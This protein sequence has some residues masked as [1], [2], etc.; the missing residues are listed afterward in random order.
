MK[1]V[2]VVTPGGLDALRYEDVPDPVPPPGWLTLEVKAAGVNHLDVWVRKG[3]PIAR[4]PIILGSDAAGVVRET[5]ERALLNPALSCGACELC[6][7]GDKPMCRDYEIFGEHRDGAQAGLIVAPPASLIP[8][9]DDLSFEEAAA[10]PLVFLTAWRM[11]LTRGRLRAGED[12]LI[13]GAG[14]GVGVACVQLAKLAGARVIAT[15]SSDA[16]AEKVAA[17]GADL[18][19]NPSKEDVVA[20]IKALTGKRGVDVV[21]DYVGK[22]TWT[23]SL[24][25]LRRG[26]RLL[27]CGATSGHD[28]VEDLRHV[29]YRQLEIIG[30]TMGSDRELKDVLDLLFK[31]RIRAPLDVVLPLSEVKDA[32][33]R[34]ESRAS[35]GKIVLRP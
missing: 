12:V 10:A 25:C 8:I 18:V 26:G 29:Y 33:R 34:L 32:Q 17:L 16:K 23:R 20:R 11:L 31:K 5:G 28:P 3:L 4:Y 35:C 30:S 19:L 2:R 21:V 9:P 27:T 6:A 1:A 7:A 14:A 13:W 15:A 22:D 24:Q